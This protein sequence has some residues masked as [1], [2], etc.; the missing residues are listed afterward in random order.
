MDFRGCFPAV[1]QSSIIVF[2]FVKHCFL[3]FQISTLYFMRNEHRLFDILFVVYLYH[4]FLIFRFLFVLFYILLYLIVPFTSVDVRYIHKMHCILS[5]EWYTC[6]TMRLFRN[7]SSGRTLTCRVMSGNYC[8]QD[9]CCFSYR[10]VEGRQ[11]QTDKQLEAGR[12]G[13][14]VCVD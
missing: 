6:S 9:W 4:D 13:Q 2:N 8:K 14:Q 5:Q 12:D 1:M 10:Q 11:N 7:L 3:P